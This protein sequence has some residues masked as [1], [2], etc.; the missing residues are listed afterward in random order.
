MLAAI[1]SG[2]I[3]INLVPYYL[4]QSFHMPKCAST[5]T[6]L[7]MYR[8]RVEKKRKKRRKKEK[9]KKDLDPAKTQGAYASNRPGWVYPLAV[10]TENPLHPVTGSSA[11]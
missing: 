2:R 5:P 6:G 11:L 7:W 9:K 4:A 10:R 1:G 8:R 3:M